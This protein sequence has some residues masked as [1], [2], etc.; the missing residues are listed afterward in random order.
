MGV[1]SNK[2]IAQT[3]MSAQLRFMEIAKIRFSIPFE[4]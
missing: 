1:L 3:T 4:K 2:K